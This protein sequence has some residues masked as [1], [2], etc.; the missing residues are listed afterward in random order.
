MHSE[1][2]LE[3]V[4]KAIDDLKGQEIR[5]LD[6]R[7]LTSITDYMVIVSGTS[8]RHVKSLADHVIDRA[9]DAGA[10]TGGIE[11]GGG[12]GWVLVDLFDVVVHVMLPSVRDFYALERLWE[13][14]GHRQAA[15]E[16]QE[17]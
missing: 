2:L 6:V 10:S 4:S 13:P 5:V 3:V 17:D 14:G 8:D 11:G 12:S 9:K 16:R 15:R 1:V 7:E